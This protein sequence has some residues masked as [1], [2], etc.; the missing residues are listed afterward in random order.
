MPVKCV[1]A[2][3]SNQGESLEILSSAVSELSKTPGLSVAKVSSVYRTKPVGDAE[4]SD[5]LNLVLLAESGLVPPVLLRRTQ[6][7][8][9]EYGRLRDPLRP[10]GPRTLDIDI[11]QVSGYESKTSELTLPHPAAYS[12]AFVLVPWLEIDPE[13]VLPQGRIS[14][15][16]PNLDLSG[17]EKYR[18][19]EL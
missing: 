14:D 8:E 13:A 2:L 5:F 9:K 1:F 7:I 10:K 17:I 19:I 4:Q 11:I 12:R 15:L 6:A 3:G 16:V 18:E